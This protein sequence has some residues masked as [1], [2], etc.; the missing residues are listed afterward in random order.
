MSNTSSNWPWESA[1][2][3]DNKKS[4][5][6]KQEF[7]NDFRNEINWDNTKKWVNFLNSIANSSTN[8]PASA[9]TLMQSFKEKKGYSK[10]KLDSITLSDL[11]NAFSK[12]LYW[13]RLSR[14][15]VRNKFY[16]EYKIDKTEK[17]DS[18][19]LP[20]LENLTYSEL[21]ELKKSKKERY[22][23][24]EKYLWKDNIP[25]ENNNVN[26]FFIEIRWLQNKLS[27]LNQDQ[28]EEVVRILQTL[29]LRD[30]SKELSWNVIEAI[31]DLL[32]MDVLSYEV[33]KKLIIDFIP[34]LSFQDAIDWGVIS[35]SDSSSKIKAKK[36]LLKNLFWEDITDEMAE[37][38]SDDELF[39]NT[40]DVLNNSSIINITKNSNLADLIAEDYNDSL[41]KAVDKAK[42]DWPQTLE[43]V[44]EK[45][46]EIQS[47]D[48]WSSRIK[49]LDKLKPGN[50]IKISTQ[51]WDWKFRVS[52]VRFIKADDKTQELKFLWIWWNKDWWTEEVINFKSND[53][54]A[55]LSYLAFVNNFDWESSTKIECFTENEIKA[56]IEDPNSN[57]KS[58]DL[59]LLNEEDLK[60]PTLKKSVQK[61]YKEK[62][63]HEL[64]ELEEKLWHWHGDDSHWHDN[65]SHD[66]HWHS[67]K[68]EPDPLLK[69]KIDDI[70][71]K[72]GKIDSLDWKELLDFINLEK[73][74]QKID[75]EDKEWASLW[76]S[77]WLIL[78]TEDWGAFEI[79]WIDWDKIII[80][81]TYSPMEKLDF[82]TFYQSFKKNKTKRVKKIND[83]NELLQSY[84]WE[85]SWK[86]H[87]FKDGKIIAK[88]A[89]NWDEK[90]DQ[91]VEYFISWDSDEVI[92]V[93]SVSWDKITIQFWE[94]WDGK[95]HGHLHEDHWD[96]HDDHW[97]DDHWHWHWD[98]KPKVETE[99][100]SLYKDT[101]TITLNEFNKYI[102]WKKF[103]PSWKTWKT[104]KW[105][106]SEWLT[107]KIK[108]KFWT[109]LFNNN[110]SLA[111]LQA[112]IKVLTHSVEHTLKK[113]TDFHAAKI[114]VGIWS[115]VLPHDWV[116][117]LE[118]HVEK[119]E[120]EEME[121]ELKELW[122]I[123]SKLAVQRIKEWLLNKDIP[124][125]KKEAW[126][127]FMIEKYWHLT[128][129]WPLYPYRWKFLWYEAFGWRINDELFL[130]VKKEEEEAWTAFS[131]EKLLHMLLKEQCKHHW[132][133]WI[134]R[135]S[136]LH[137]EF[138]NKIKSW[139]EA[140]Y[141][142]W[143][144][145]ASAKR[146]AKTMVEWWVDEAFGWTT[147]NTIWWLKR[148][149]ERWWSMEDMSEWFF[150]LM[151]SWA[152]Y[153]VEQKTLVMLKKVRDDWHTL[154][155]PALWTKVPDIKLFNQTVLE[156]SKRI[157]DIYPEY[158][159]IAKEAQS[160]YDL[161][162]NKKWDESKLIKKT[163]QF[164][165]KYKKPLSRA[166]NMNHHKDTDTAKTDKIIFLEQDNP[167]FKTYY[168]KARELIDTEKI[169]ES[170]M[171]D[172]VWAYWW[173]WISMYEV[174]KKIM[175]YHTSWG[176][177]N[178]KASNYLWAAFVSEMDS[179]KS[180]VSEWWLDKEDA[181]KYIVR[182]LKDL[183]AAFIEKH[184][185][186]KD[187]IIEANKNSSVMWP[188][189]NE[190]WINFYEQFYDKDFGINDILNWNR[191]DHIFYAAAENIVSWNK[192]TRKEDTSWFQDPFARPKNV[193]KSKVDKLVSSNTN[194]NLGKH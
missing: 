130:K 24:L 13:I 50:I 184:S 101:H 125:Y 192:L 18:K 32:Q 85:D 138:E 64:H 127:M 11:K 56:E 171:A 6:T 91:E 45:M 123:D 58:S 115:K 178:E 116:Y 98:S 160:I 29:E 59:S 162:H 120:S 129:K 183:T 89:Q 165:K 55:P 60:D 108:P 154:I 109:R 46:T 10:I 61:S 62:L 143:Y 48:S 42:K 173:A 111:E 1:E 51:L 137:K 70:K 43:W 132:Y 12:E 36:D 124:D 4:S 20:R 100:I 149:V 26:D 17:F 176:M 139:I 119:E 47:S 181:K 105:V 19:I 185:T 54:I 97:H 168:N 159:W 73:L 179:M 152:L 7:L 92:R 63:E 150:T 79:G 39:L 155:M 175:V 128:S 172:A 117:D 170:H 147:S 144:K 9:F 33:R 107:N 84:N 134:K 67:Q 169:K 142:K 180:R 14:Q 90:W 103:S 93:K 71:S 77:K 126:M 3:Q 37:K 110:Y 75:E 135:R 104:V 95:D 74:I 187:I 88:D 25:E 44:I 145:D 118:S 141:E 122:S 27:S 102:K 158:H 28:K 81:S 31:R 2:T 72:L 15:F 66:D 68:H 41:E 174:A 189:L 163:N 121:K 86:N 8:V 57:I 40:K 22:N 34:S 16:S 30:K 167:I 136:R 164:W 131:E 52:Y 193:T 83:F 151:Y 65:H 96:G 177:V 53:D 188:K 69:A 99:H 5:I 106:E 191:V 190:W 21:N 140:E 82:E 23:F 153:N 186:K 182:A 133:K 161:A 35:F 78:E 38:V 114:A 148:A 156:L 157:E 194:D 80:K 87:E 146:T 94:R 166:L 113:W 49:S 76:L 112:W